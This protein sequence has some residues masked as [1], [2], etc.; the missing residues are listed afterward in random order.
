VNWAIFVVGTILFILGVLMIIFRA[1][2]ARFNADLLR[3]FWGSEGA[4]TARRS[5]STQVALAGIFL[6]LL[7]TFLIVRAFLSH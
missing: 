1:R 5:T 7:S 6:V 4:E 2:L 3:S